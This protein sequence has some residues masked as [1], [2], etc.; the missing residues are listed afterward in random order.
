M[1]PRFFETPADLHTWFAANHETAGEIL[2]GFHKVGS[3]RRSITWPEAVDEALCVGWI[4]G[5]RRRIDDSSYSIRFTPR[6]KGGIWSAVNIARVAELT[7]SGR[8]QPAGFRAFE[9]RSEAKSAIYAYEQPRASFA[10]DEESQ[11]RAASSAW[12]WFTAQAPSYQKT[13]TYWV[14]S[15]RKPETRARRL[16]TLI[17]DSEAGRTIRHLT[18]PS[19]RDPQ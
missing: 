8:M 18:R 11:F 13:A 10:P 19:P 16:A 6:R 5:I 3:G 4:D 2:V 1:E 14:V 7:E 12:M 9:A 17:A 15:A